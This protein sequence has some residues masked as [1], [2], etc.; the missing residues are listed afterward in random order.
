MEAREE[1]AERKRSIFYLKGQIRQDSPIKR[2]ECATFGGL[3]GH[4]NQ[5]V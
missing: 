3:T 4:V 2:G 5:L 1:Y